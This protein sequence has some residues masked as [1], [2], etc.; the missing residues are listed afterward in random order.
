MRMTKRCGIAPSILLM[1]TIEAAVLVAGR[2]SAVAD[3][4]LL[5]SQDNNGQVERPWKCCDVTVCTR[6]IPPTCSCMDVVD[7]CAATCK[8]CKPRYPP[9]RVC[10]DKYTG[11]PGPKCTDDH[12]DGEPTPLQVGDVAFVAAEGLRLH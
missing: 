7:N 11:D 6:S 2:S 12:I 1:L 8:A 10:L 9:R 4:I 5:P 3:D